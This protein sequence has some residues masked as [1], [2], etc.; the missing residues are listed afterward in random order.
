[1]IKIFLA[2]GLV[3]NWQQ[4]VIDACTDME[5]E[6]KFYNPMAQWGALTPWPKAA[7]EQRVWLDDSDIVF[8]YIE[9]TNP[10][11]G[12]IGVYEMGRGAGGGAFTILVNEHN[13]KYPAYLSEHADIYT[14]SF[15]AGILV[16]RDIIKQTQYAR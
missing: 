13:N 2:G 4:K 15:K 8:L 10:S 7:R 3:T 9:A 6:H 11:M 14:N 16:L 1:M 12:L 5:I